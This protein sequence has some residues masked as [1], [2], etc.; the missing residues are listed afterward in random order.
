MTKN[1]IGQTHCR[2][3][4]LDFILFLTSFRGFLPLSGQLRAHFA[5]YS[6]TLTGYRWYFIPRSEKKMAMICPDGRICRPQRLAKER[7]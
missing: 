2:A 5:L 7:L 3:W 1:W 6:E 4:K